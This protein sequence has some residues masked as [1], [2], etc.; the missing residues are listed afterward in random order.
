VIWDQLDRLL[1]D[2]RPDTSL[3]ARRFEQLANRASEYLGMVFHRFLEDSASRLVTITVNRGKVEPWN[4]FAPM[5]RRTVELPGRLFEL[6]DGD[7]VAEVTGGYA[8]PS[9]GEDGTP[10]P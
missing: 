10:R 1:P 3:T 6:V 7:K 4:P 8:S 2:K 5:E 9:R